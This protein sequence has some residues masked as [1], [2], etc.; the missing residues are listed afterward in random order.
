MNFLPSHFFR[1]L[2]IIFHLLFPIETTLSA[3]FR[4]FIRQ[5]YGEGVEK[6]FYVLFISLIENISICVF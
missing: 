1:I 3:K 5:N 6:E 2:P 4:T